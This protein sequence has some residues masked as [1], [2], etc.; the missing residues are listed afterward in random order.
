MRVLVT[1]GAGYI[2]SHTVKS[3]LNSGHEPIVI[4][5]FVN[6]HEWIVKNVLKVPFIKGSIGN[7]EL[8]NSIINGEHENLKGT[9]HEKKNIEGILHFAAFAYVGESVNEPLKYYSNNVL[10]TLNMLK[11]IYENN[12]SIKINLAFL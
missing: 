1:G 8:I 4:D 11:V 12:L 3:L 7:K 2:G 9:V 6:G 10:Q 5:S